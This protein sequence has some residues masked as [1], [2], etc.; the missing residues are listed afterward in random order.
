MTPTVAQPVALESAPLPF[1]LD[2][3]SY[4]GPSWHGSPPLRA[5]LYSALQSGVH[6]L[7]TLVFEADTVLDHEPTP[8]PPLPPIPS[9]EHLVLHTLSHSDYTFRHD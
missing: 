3:L 7:E 6:I 4:T 1:S 2:A 8:F 9:M 5:L